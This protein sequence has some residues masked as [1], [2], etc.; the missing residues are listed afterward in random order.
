M[1]GSKAQ[2]ALDVSLALALI[3][4]LQLAHPE[5]GKN[6][7]HHPFSLKVRDVVRR[8]VQ[9]AKWEVWSGFLLVEVFIKLTTL[10][11]AL[12]CSV[13]RIVS[14]PVQTMQSHWGPS[15]IDFRWAE[16]QLLI[17]TLPG[18]SCRLFLFWDLHTL[19]P[20]VKS[21]SMSLV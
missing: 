5:G 1:N 2:L 16:E 7:H 15:T 20:A 10:Y 21:K 19:R 14:R 3:L 8:E 9:Q 17:P 13:F 18:R 12:S 11:I 4:R 6:N